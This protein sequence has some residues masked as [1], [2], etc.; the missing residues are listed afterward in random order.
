VLA[1]EERDVADGERERYLAALA[2]RRAA[3]RAAGAHFWV[4]ER[5]GAPGRFV[6]FTE[7]GSEDALRA[8]GGGVPPGSLWHEV[9]GG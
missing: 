4:F 5:A 7:A 2:A 6:E 9:G 3:A 8:A 1:F